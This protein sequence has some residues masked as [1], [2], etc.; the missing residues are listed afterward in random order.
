LN[1]RLTAQKVKE[2]LTAEAQAQRESAKAAKEAADQK[3]KAVKATNDLAVSLKGNQTAIT[4][5]TQAFKGDSLAANEAVNTYKKLQSAGV[6][7]TNIQKQLSTQLKITS[8][9]FDTINN[10]PVN[11]NFVKS[12]SEK[13]E[14]LQNTAI[15]GTAVAGTIGVGLL[16]GTK[17]FIAYEDA[18]KK[19]GITAEIFGTEKLA[20]FEKTVTKLGQAT[21]KTPQEIANVSIELV[22]AGFSIEET[23]KALPSLIDGSLASGASLSSIGDIAA[24]AVRQFGLTANDIPRVI[25]ALVGAANAGN[26][27]VESLGESLKYVGVSGREA[28]QPVEDVIGLL[29]LLGDAALQGGQGGRNLDTALTRLKIASAEA[30]PEVMSLVRGSARMREAFDLLGVS[31]R[32]ADTKQLKPLLQTLPVIKA[33][34]SKF[35]KGERDIIL[36]A[37]FDTEGGRAVGA[38]LTRT[39]ADIDKVEKAS[40]NLGVAAKAGKD[41]LSG[42]SGA[43]VQLDSSL[44]TLSIATGKLQSSALEP[45]ALTAKDL[46]NTFLASP[47]IVQQLV[48]GVTVLTGAIAAAIAVTATYQLLKISEAAATVAE[49]AATILST[50]AT[51]AATAAKF[52]FNTQITLAGANQ[53]KLSAQTAI[54]SIATQVFTGNTITATGALGGLKFALLSVLAPLA[55]LGAGAAVVGIVKTT[56]ALQ[57]QNDI[58]EVLNARTAIVSDVGL[59][60]QQ[61]LKAAI[62]SVNASRQKGLAITEQEKQNAKE[63]LANAE[64]ALT[65]LKQQLDDAQKTPEV[66]NTGFRKAL[67][68]VTTGEI[69]SKGNVSVTSSADAQNKNRET[70]INLIKRQI[71]AIEA[72]KATLA[73]AIDP[74]IKEGDAT[75]KNTESKKES[76]ERIQDETQEIKRNADAIKASETIKER[77]SERDRSRQLEKE[78]RVR[79]KTEDKA[80]DT[81]KDQESK[82]TDALKAIQE[83]EINELRKRNEIEIET[84]KKAFEN[85]VLNPLRK[86]NDAEI[87]E[88]NKDFN[89]Q[90]NTIKRS[91][92]AVIRNEQKSFNDRE[93][94]VARAFQN[95]LNNDRKSLERTLNAEKSALEKTLNSEKKAFDST[96]NGASKAFESGITKDQSKVDRTLKLEDPEL[97]AKAKAKLKEDFAKEDTLALRREQ[98]QAPIEAKKIAFEEAQN[99][100]KEEF[101][102]AQNKKKELLEEAQNKKK[103]EFE[104]AQNKK[105]EEFE[106]A[107]NKKKE[108]FEVNVITPLKLQ[109]DEALA[110]ARLS[111]EDKVITPL[112]LKQQ[113]QINNTSLAFEE[114]TLNPIRLKLADA[115]A[116]KNAK[117]EEAIQKIKDRYEKTLEARKEKFD[118]KERKLDDIAQDAAEKRKEAFNNKQRNADIATAERIEAI[119]NKTKVDGDKTPTTTPTQTNRQT[120]QGRRYGG[121]VKANTPYQIFDDGKSTPEIFIPDANGSVL[122]QQQV[123]QN[124]AALQRVGQAKF[125]TPQQVQSIN[126]NGQLLAE[127]QMLRNTI[128]SRSPNMTVPVTFKSD[129]NGYRSYDRMIKLQ[130]AHLRSTI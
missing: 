48:F 97:D 5:V 69:D 112:K 85:D 63:S 86:N 76:K 114:K 89:T 125:N 121:N 90:E 24:K 117:N 56:E 77:A 14:A 71:E 18:I 55:V 113:E 78:K 8:D 20:N 104:E 53:L 118:D 129:D 16:K 22:R 32:D 15:V 4:A 42:L 65:L 36:K 108:E 40:R 92:E 25:D 23:A 67:D 82:E 37:L 31:I 105:K 29:T 116:V 130:M 44:S 62:D 61:K 50:G 83:K 123:R 1:A 95:D 52:L 128:E 80:I 120:I 39:Q 68:F 127:I 87:R 96:L 73:S 38:L 115:I 102:E 122:T 26:V 51:K 28:N 30:N 126:Q 110:N 19:V 107:Q 119:R 57:E 109:Q 94:S 10:T 100:K 49:T 93:R 74:I 35:D 33:Q 41:S 91:N 47:P 101:E 84:A 46:I 75:K 66:K 88:L 9:Q 64:K 34:L 6:E 58:L 81:I 106:E 103:E 60:A 7:L 124:L 12:E 43:T 27:S 79:A 98:L 99:K 59:N 54:S 72:Q 17:D 2:S 3:Q 111:F 13:Q 21:A 70:N 11:K 45:L